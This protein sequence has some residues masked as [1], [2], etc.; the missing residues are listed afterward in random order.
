MEA[1]PSD[2]QSA[3]AADGGFNVLTPEAWKAQL[4]HYSHVVLVANSEAVDFKRIA[5]DGSLRLLQQCL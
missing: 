1:I 4:S 2:T 5:G 3:A